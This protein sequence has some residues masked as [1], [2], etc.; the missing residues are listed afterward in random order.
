MQVQV[1]RP[2]LDNIRDT[3]RAFVAELWISINRADRSLEEIREPRASFVL[4]FGRSDTDAN[5]VRKLA[6]MLRHYGW[7]KRAI[8][9]YYVAMVE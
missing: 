2:C 8:R 6:E 9:G 1:L 3:M 4:L 7:Q 5:N